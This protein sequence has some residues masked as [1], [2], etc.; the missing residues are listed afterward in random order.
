MRSYRN[1]N[2]SYGVTENKKIGVILEFENKEDNNLGIPLPK[3]KIRVY[4]K[5][6]ADNSL[7]FIGEDN[8]D[9]TPRGEKVKIKIGIV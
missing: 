1:T 7:E 5:D 8:I 6:D 2:A 4:K 9:H 3:G